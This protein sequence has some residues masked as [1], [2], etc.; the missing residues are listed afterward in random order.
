M[1]GRAD[2]GRLFNEDEKAPGVAQR[3]AKV[4]VKP[5]QPT[6]DLN[7]RTER[8]WAGKAPDLVTE[9]EPIA[10]VFAAAARSRTAPSAIISSALPAKSTLSSSRWGPAPTSAAQSIAA[11]A[12]RRPVIEAE[13]MSE[14]PL[15]TE[16]PPRQPV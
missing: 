15:P 7:R 12:Q 11:S 6:A 1:F 13:V 5:F 9:D 2:L 14:A 4:A 3:D 16:A 10:P 8:Y